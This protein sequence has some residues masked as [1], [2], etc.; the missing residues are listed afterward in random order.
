MRKD[1][2]RK[3]FNP[4]SFG[5]YEERADADLFRQ[6]YT[7][8]EEYVE[9]PRVDMFEKDGSIITKVELPGVK[10]EDIGVEIEG[11]VLTVRAT[12]TEEHE[13]K[14]GNYYQSERFNGTLERVM[15]LPG[16]V[17]LKSATAVYKH[18]ILEL[19]AKKTDNA[20]KKKVKI[21]VA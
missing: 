11:N 5:F 16:F 8:M 18:G 21:K 9:L 4:F 10:T 19:T 12:R 13:I 3:K 1:I 15:E 20:S 6:P 7:M 14:K 17:D 2:I